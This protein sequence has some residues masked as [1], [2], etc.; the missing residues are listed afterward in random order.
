MTL[1]N[2]LTKMQQE[3]DKRGFYQVG[4]KKFYSKALAIMESQQS[5][6]YPEFNFNDQKFST[7]NWGKEPEQSLQEIYR[8][9]ALQ[10]REKYDYLVLSYSSGSDSTNIL[11]S[12]LFNGIK[13]D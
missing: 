2:T 1:H 3:W 5:G 4:Q 11:H 13:I 10:L 8:K 7:Y 12:F 6:I 9:R